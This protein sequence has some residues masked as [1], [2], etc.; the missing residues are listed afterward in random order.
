MNDQSAVIEMFDNIS[1]EYDHLNHLLSFGIDRI[2][3]RK[4]SKWVSQNHPSAILDVA[5]G[6]ADLAIQLASDNPEAYITGIDLS[7]KMLSVGSQKIDKKQLSNRVHMEVADAAALPFSNDSYDVVTVAF[8]VRNFSDR[9]AGLR[10]MVRVCRNGGF[11]AILEFSHPRNPLIKVPYRWYSKRWIPKVGR[12]V[13]KHP[14]AYSYLPSSVEAFPDTEVFMETLS[15]AGLSDIKTK[16][17]SGG[18]ATL[19][20]GRASKNHPLPQ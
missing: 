19:Y 17:L 14:S 3:R 9:G 13:S 15:K 4:I 16:A 8:G 18:I 11:I 12:S 1:P 20:C 6:T 5:T 10:E 2:W 7:E